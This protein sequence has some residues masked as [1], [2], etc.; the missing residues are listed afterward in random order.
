MQKVNINSFFFKQ[1]RSQVGTVARA[2]KASAYWAAGARD[3]V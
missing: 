1:T 3:C 2:L